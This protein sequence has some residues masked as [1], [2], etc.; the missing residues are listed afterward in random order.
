MG[1]LPEMDEERGCV[2]GERLGSTL[3]GK[4][5]KDEADE[6]EYPVFIGEDWGVYIHEREAVAKGGHEREMADKIY[7][8]QGTMPGDNGL[9]IHC[10]D[11]MRNDTNSILRCPSK[12]SVL[13]C[14][15]HEKQTL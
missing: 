6:L 2:H 3:N 15:K 7:L 8:M 1:I 14:Q 4:R 5:F 13:Q 10:P 9:S 12:G 11:T